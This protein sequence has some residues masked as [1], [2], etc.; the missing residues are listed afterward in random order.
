[1]NKTQ[2]LPVKMILLRI[3]I[4]AKEKSGAGSLCIAIEKRKSL[5]SLDM[6]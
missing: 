3:G 5:Y 4:I 1:M 6:D 2:C